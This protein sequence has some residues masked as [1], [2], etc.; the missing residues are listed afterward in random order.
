MAGESRSSGTAT[1]TQAATALPTSTP[2]ARA[3]VSSSR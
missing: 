3:V 1:T 2:G